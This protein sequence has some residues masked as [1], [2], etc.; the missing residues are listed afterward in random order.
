MSFINV[1]SITIMFLVSSGWI[2]RFKSQKIQNIL[3]T[4]LTFLLIYVFMLFGFSIMKL[5]EVGTLQE[6]LNTRV[7]YMVYLVFIVIVVFANIR[8][9]GYEM[10][11]EH[12]DD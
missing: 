1:A 3:E 5:I 6:M 7:E 4:F 10:L 11:G 9:T 2:S 12:Y 8:R